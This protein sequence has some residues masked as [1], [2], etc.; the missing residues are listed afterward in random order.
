MWLNSFTKSHKGIHSTWGFLFP[1]LVNKRNS[2]PFATG[3]RRHQ[4]AMSKLTTRS[5]LKTSWWWIGFCCLCSSPTLQFR[6]YQ[7]RESCYFPDQYFSIIQHFQI[8]YIMQ[9]QYPFIIEKHTFSSCL[10]PSYELHCYQLLNTQTPLGAAALLLRKDLDPGMVLDRI[11]WW[12]HGVKHPPQKGVLKPL[13]P[14]FASASSAQCLN[15]CEEPNCSA[16]ASRNC[17]AVV[18]IKTQSQQYSASKYTQHLGKEQ[19]NH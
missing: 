9:S 15:H 4:Q 5:S 17:C 11:I 8:N 14:V 18:K 19:Q 2:H 7:R 16:R 3:N 12:K 10:A 6:P 13:V 1:L